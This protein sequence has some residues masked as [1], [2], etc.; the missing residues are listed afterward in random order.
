MGAA[1]TAIGCGGNGGN[2][3]NAQPKARDT[4]VVGLTVSP[5]N[6]DPD[7]PGQAFNYGSQLVRRNS[8]PY[9]TDF[10]VTGSQKRLEPSTSKLKNL[11]FESLESNAAGDV[12][13]ARIRSGAKWAGGEPVTAEDFRWSKERGLHYK[14]NVAFIYSLMGIT[15]PDQLQALDERTIEFRQAFPSALTPQLHVITSWMYN[16]NELKRHAKA[17]DPWA[18]DWRNATPPADGGL[19]NVTSF[20]PGKE[21]VLERNP[22]YAAEDSVAKVRQVRMPVATE[23]SLGLQLQRGDIDI[24]FGLSRTAAYRLKDRKGVVVAT[25]PSANVAALTMLVSE[26]PFDDVL[27]RRAI[28]MAMPYELILRNMWHGAGR[29]SKSYLPLDT[30]G[31]TDAYPYEQ[32]LE[33]AKLLLGRAGKPNGFTTEL[34]IAAGDAELQR[35]AVLVADELKKLKIETKIS[36]LDA[37]TYAERRAKKD[38]PLNLATAAAGWVNDADY[39]LAFWYVTGAP[40]NVGNYS[41]SE[42][43]KIHAEASKIV[44]EGKR[45]ELFA[46]AQEVLAEDVPSV[47]LGQPDSVVAMREASGYVAMPDQLLRLNYL[48]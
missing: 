40:G 48:S 1:L 44:D 6:W 12:W 11:L 8:Y 25:R 37:A 46:R 34:A 33:Q 18:Q 10:G 41:S 23:A 19:F 30:P 45:L 24:A 14:G 27:V 7:F 16:K 4:L 9:G 17:G 2:G 36:Q 22:D 42:I 28:A 20:T 32:D 5:A 26:P 47:L 29:A 21:V 38:V 3:G 13:T 39:A 15:T 31:R 35:L 43:D